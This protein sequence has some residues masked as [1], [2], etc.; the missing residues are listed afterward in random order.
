MFNGNLVSVHSTALAIHHTARTFCQ[1][2]GVTESSIARAVFTW[3]LQAA[4]VPAARVITPCLSLTHRP[5]Q[6]LLICSSTLLSQLVLTDADRGALGSGEMLMR[7]ALGSVVLHRP[8]S[9][10]WKRTPKEPSCPPAPGIPPAQGCARP[11]SGT[12]LLSCQSTGLTNFPIFLQTWSG[13][14]EALMADASTV[15]PSAFPVVF[16]LGSNVNFYH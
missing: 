11:S 2:G 6:L 8:H 12:D 7:R 15:T 5:P 10:G 9:C 4:A 14:P 1:P 13:D 16:A 3:P